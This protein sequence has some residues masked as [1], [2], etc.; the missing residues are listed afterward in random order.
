MKRKH[1]IWTICWFAIS[2]SLVACGSETGDQAMTST[3]PSSAAS[4]TSAPQ[5]ATPE[6]TTPTPDEDGKKIDIGGRNLYIRCEGTG[7]PT[8]I[9]DS[10]LGNDWSTWSKVMPEISGFTQVCAYDRAGL[11]RSDSASPPRTSQD[12]V[13]D[14]HTLLAQANVPGPYVLVGHS[15]AGFNVRLYAHKYPDSVAGIVLVDSTHPDQTKAFSDALPPE[16]PDESECVKDLREVMKMASDPKISPE[17]LDF[18]ASEAQVRA[19]GS[20]GDLPLVVVTRGQSACGPTAPED[21]ANIDQAW[22]KLQSE[23]VDLSSN[24]TQIVAERS[25]H[26]IP[27]EQPDAVID[28]VQRIVDE[29]KKP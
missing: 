28:A 7:A 26:L 16:S 18:E 17:G 11:G 20:L 10:G 22:Q 13:E 29:T 8:V 12:M 14:L 3:V 23:L 15:L 19:A 1:I 9:L 27:A 24:G 4:S 21:A 5:A 2:L 25:G 6:S